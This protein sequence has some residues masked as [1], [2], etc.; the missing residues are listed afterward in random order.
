MQN[1]K[2][3]LNRCWGRTPTFRRCGRFGIWKFFCDDHR[4][5]PVGWI[6]ALLF[7]VGGGIASIQSAWFPD[8]WEKTPNHPTSTAQAPSIQ[9]PHD[10]GTFTDSA[11]VKVFK[12]VPS[13]QGPKV[14]LEYSWKFGER[15]SG[16]V[17][18]NDGTEAALNI[19]FLDVQATGWGIDFPSVPTL[20]KGDRVTVAPTALRQLSPPH[21]NRKRVRFS[22][23]IDQVARALPN[24]E[25]I[26]ITVNLAYRSASSDDRFESHYVVYYSR[27]E[28]S[29]SARF[30]GAGRIVPKTP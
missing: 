22:Y 12:T 26:E 15:D 28:K 25:R 11:S 14:L 20:K 23:F 7:T 16:F 8:V 19:E 13:Q 9:G 1:E 2:A 10:N 21:S 18:F 6:C 3:H 30:I 24:P 29:A 4:I 27:S 17:L 5:Q